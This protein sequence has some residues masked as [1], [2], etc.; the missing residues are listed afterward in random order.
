MV[1]GTAQDGGYPHIGCREKCCQPAWT[2]S[3]KKRLISSIA[4]IH[5][6]SKKCWIIDISPNI[7]TQLNMIMNFLEIDNI[8]KI[9]GIFLTHAHTGHYS[10]LLDL[11]KEALN[12]DNIPLYAMPEMCNFIESNNPFKFL[13]ESKNIYLKTIKEGQKNQLFNDISISSFLVPH[14]NELSETVGYRIS[15]DKNIIYLPDIDSW[16]EW[17][18]DIV[19][20][21][22]N[23][24]VLFLDGTF[25]HKNEISHRDI[26]VIPHPSIVESLEKFSDLDKIDRSKIFF[27]HLNHTNTVIQDDHPSKSSI[28]YDG[29]SVAEDGQIFYI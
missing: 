11:G 5:K 9:E 13:I 18:Q 10:G 16:D 26:S 15:S 4:I 23:N 25:Y 28:I 6:K 27:T 7:K 20:V 2:D 22:K 12:T 21:V 24:D 8:P 17:D 14:R 19:D 3:S 1:L 29:Y